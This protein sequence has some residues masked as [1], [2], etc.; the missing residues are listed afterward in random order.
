MDDLIF[1]DGKF[2]LN[3]IEKLDWDINADEN[4]DILESLECSFEGTVLAVKTA[5]IL[6]A[7]QD[8]EINDMR[9]GRKKWPKKVKLTSREEFFQLLA[10]HVPLSEYSK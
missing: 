9:M 10:L 5:S 4:K 3:Q 8:E 1:L 7:L 2:H 6:S